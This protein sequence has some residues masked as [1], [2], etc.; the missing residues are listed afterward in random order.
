MKANHAN[1][2][3]HASV[4][5]VHRELRVLAL[6]LASVLAG[7]A[8]MPPPVQVTL[9]T[10]RHGCAGSTGSTFERTSRQFW[11]KDGRLVVHVRLRESGSVSVKPDLASVEVKGNLVTLTYETVDPT[12]GTGELPIMCH[13]SIQGTFTIRGLDPGSYYVLVAS[14]SETTWNVEYSLAIPE[15]EESK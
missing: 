8:M 1:G 5:R 2:E 12:K 11:E 14:Q 6:A 13:W 9:E 3:A 4:A 10:K 7:C 15:P